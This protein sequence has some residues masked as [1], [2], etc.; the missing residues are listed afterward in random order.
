[1]VAP[2]STPPDAGPPQGYV[3]LDLEDEADA[4]A[5]REPHQPPA[6]SSAPPPFHSWTGENQ[7]YNL[8]DPTKRAAVQEAA[9]ALQWPGPPPAWAGTTA[10]G[11][12][13]AVDRLHAPCSSMLR[14]LR[15]RVRW[16]GAPTTPTP[17]TS[18]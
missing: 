8:H 17:R 9:A 10:G 11:G 18:E 5:A 13:E 6:S 4:S 15:L 2:S 12:G 14:W 16:P 3:A 7:G 1:M